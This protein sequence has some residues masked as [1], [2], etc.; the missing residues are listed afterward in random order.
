MHSPFRIVFI[1]IT[2]AIC[3]LLCIPKLD[4]SLLP[5][6]QSQTITVSYSVRNSNP[7]QTEEKATSILENTFSQLK[8]LKKIESFSGYNFGKIS[9]HFGNEQDMSYRK[10]EVNAL[11]RQVKTK[12][13][14]DVSYPTISQETDN[15]SST[16]PILTYTY[17]SS[18][19]NSILREEAE[20]FIKKK[21]SGISGIKDIIVSGV[22]GQQINIFYDKNKL[23]SYHIDVEDIEKSLNDLSQVLYPGLIKN[24]NNKLEFIKVVPSVLDL[25]SLGKTQIKSRRSGNIIELKN[26]ASIS[27]TEQEAQDYFRINGENAVN[28]NIYANSDVNSIYLA[29]QIKENINSFKNTLNNNNLIELSFD[30]TEFLQKEIDKNYQRTT[31]ALLILTLF[32][33]VSYKD[34]KH[35]LN[36]F[37]SLV[38]N[39]SLTILI[40]WLCNIQFH[41]YTLGGIAIAFGIM[42][43]HS[44]IMLDYYRQYRNTKVFM[45]L[46]GATLTTIVALSLVFYL[47]QNEQNKLVDFS[48]IIIIALASSLITNLWFT[49]SLYNLLFKNELN[50]KR[51]RKILGLKRLIYY[52]QSYT[53]IIFWTS[54]HRKK[55]I[56][57]LI[58]LFGIPIYLLPPKLND[59][60]WYNESIGSERY[61]E[62][63][64][65]VL[66]KWLGGT[67]RFFNENTFQESE[68]RELGRSRLNVYAQLPIGNTLEQMNDVIKEMELYLKGIEGIDQF[69]TS[70]NSGQI[71]HIE[72]TFKK[73]YENSSFPIQFKS[74]L[75]EKCYEWGGVTWNIDGIGQAFRNN[76]FE[77]V[78]TFKVLMKG[79]N[80]DELEKQ[81]YLLKDKLSNHR[82]VKNINVNDRAS[83]RDQTGEEYILNFKSN[84]ADIAGLN[85]R[86]IINTLGPMV[87]QTT[88]SNSITLGNKILPVFYNSNSSNEFSKWDLLN[89]TIHLNNKSLKLNDFSEFNLQK[90]AGLILK[91][92]RQYL[93]TVSFNFWGKSDIGQ[94]FLDKKIAEMRE[95]MPLGFSLSEY[96]Y[97]RQ[98]D[99]NNQNYWLILI[100][101]LGNYIICSI[102][103][104]SLKQSIYIIAIIPISFIGLFLIFSI[105]N[106][107]FD[108]GGYAAFIMLGGLVIN[109]G[110][111][112]INDFNN[113]NKNTKNK[114]I[115]NKL[116]IKSIL[117]RGRT[118]LLTI[119]ASICG[120]LPFLVEGPNEV[121]WFSLAIGTIGG[122]LFSLFAIFIVLPV[123]MWQ[124]D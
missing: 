87:V 32:V 52:S 13:S 73:Q 96:E 47:P 116:V 83:I 82:R 3:C 58:L 81:A 23:D 71:A 2:I 113:L 53:K 20:Q 51:K 33:F 117:N 14:A 114:N 76:T 106:F 22:L 43:D 99:E 54:N 9:L 41:M 65:P 11:I 70:I 39:L 102:L 92:N 46:I 121:F 64:A 93:R 105:F 95:E 118:I 49:V 7:E 98:E 34:W 74:T 50:N 60:A 37:S 109:A 16:R 31:L 42:I 40:A 56:C 57:F 26:L 111:F 78:P 101:I 122:L 112:I 38:I 86:D 103:F 120:L 8:G 21:L 59:K 5:S 79:Y 85:A 48:L 67:L 44:I 10:F 6:D 88:S 63:I 36:L 66:N 45:A 89:N 124:K 55:F 1:F 15:E 12:L 17:K 75:T 35:V 108:Q 91:E 90:T 110:I 4:I 68:S 61:Q 100:L 62:D 84:L 115:V 24:N 94:S 107:P 18:S 30:D 28:I 123:F 77:D 69:I 29:N 97:N 104:E 119:I 19:Q 72:I 27:I 80:Y 25:E